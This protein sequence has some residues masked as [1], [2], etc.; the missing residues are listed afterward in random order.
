MAKITLSDVAS[1]FASSTTVNANN[2]LVEVAVENQL[3]RD[4]TS[5]NQM[6]ADLDMNSWKVIN[7][8]DGVG[9]Q[10]AVTVSQL[11]NAQFSA[12]I[13]AIAASVV[14]VLDT[15][16]NFTA[17][18]VEAVLAEIASNYAGLGDT[19]TVTGTWTLPN[20]TVLT[21]PKAV[22]NAVGIRNP[23][24]RIISGSSSFQQDDSGQVIRYTGSGSHTLAMDTLLG[25][26]TVIV[27]NAGSGTLTLGEG[28]SGTLAFYDGGGSLST[29]DL[30]LA[31]A[32]VATIHY[33]GTNFA[34]CWGNG[35]T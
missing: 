17:S 30:T 18:D 16:A 29:G 2:A 26:T 3:S 4:G 22:A 5:P 8:T 12:T 10:D 14:T 23:G 24:E 32:G 35:L 19:E 34:D 33:T 15:A 7:V 6:E 21:D 11:S 28:G 20:T 13:E 25:G 9:A 31:I 27:K 1:G